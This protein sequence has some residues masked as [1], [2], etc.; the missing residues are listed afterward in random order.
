MKGFNRWLHAPTNDAKAREIPATIL[1][2][3]SQ[4]NENSEM[5]GDASDGQQPVKRSK[6]ATPTKADPAHSPAK[7]VSKKQKAKEKKGPND[8]VIWDLHGQ[9]DRA[10]RAMAAVLAAR[11]GKSK[12]HIEENIATMA[13]SM[14][15]KGISWLKEH[16]ERCETWAF[17]PMTNAAMEDG[18]I[19]ASPGEYLASLNRQGRWIDGRIAQAI[20]FATQNSERY[21]HVGKERKCKM[22]NDHAIAA[23]GRNPQ[24]SDRSFARWWPLCYTWSYDTCSW[25][26]EKS[27]S[28]R[29]LPTWIRQK[30]LA[31]IREGWID[32]QLDETRQRVIQTYVAQN[33]PKNPNRKMPQLL[34][35]SQ[36]PQADG[37][38]KIR[39]KTILQT[40]HGSDLDRLL[41]NRQNSFCFVYGDPKHL[42]TCPHCQMKINYCWIISTTLLEAVSSPQ[43]TSGPGRPNHLGP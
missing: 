34:Q 22:A 1:D 18:N 26:V 2:P 4:T 41:I 9:G 28:Q 24:R 14:K 5:P 27:N 12:E 16:T 42:W 36:L 37:K 38:P 25:R 19:P 31:Q 13:K 39:C 8:T 40:L 15:A 32:L 35:W 30:Q 21:Y 7:P 43:E 11:A 10:Y 23:W 29:K 17:D 6:P 33:Q 20:A 3:A